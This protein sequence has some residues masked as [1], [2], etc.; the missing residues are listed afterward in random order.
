MDHEER[1]LAMME[2][3]AAKPGDQFIA[4]FRFQDI[5]NRILV[6]YRRNVFCHCEQKKIVIPQH[7][8]NGLAETAYESEEGEGVRTSI[9]EVAREPQ[10][11]RLWIEC[12]PVEESCEWIETTL[13]VADCVDS[14]ECVVPRTA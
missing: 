4:V 12:N 9:D 5:V 14:H 10:S 13:D 1:S 3:L 8:T 11:I 2:G 7:Q 6:P